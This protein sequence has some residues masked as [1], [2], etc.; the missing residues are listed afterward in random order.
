MSTLDFPL[1]LIAT[2]L[3]WVTRLAY[4]LFVTFT[5]FNEVY[6]ITSFACG[7]LSQCNRSS[8]SVAFSNLVPR[9]LS[10]LRES[11]LVTAGHVSARF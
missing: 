2:M 4:V 6:Y 3:N 1:V 5:T 11:T 8:C 10:L 7:V 9:V